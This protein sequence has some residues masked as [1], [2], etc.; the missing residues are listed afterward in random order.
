[1]LEVE[2]TSPSIVD[3]A[4]ASVHLIPPWPSIE[5]SAYPATHGHYGSSVEAQHG[6]QPR[7]DVFGPSEAGSPGQSRTEASIAT[8]A[9]EGSRRI[10]DAGGFS[11]H[12]SSSGSSSSPIGRARSRRERQSHDRPI[13]RSTSARL[14]LSN[15]EHAISSVGDPTLVFEDPR[16]QRH[17]GLAPSSTARTRRE[18]AVAVNMLRHVDATSSAPTPTLM[19][20]AL[21]DAFFVAFSPGAPAFGVAGMTDFPWMGIWKKIT[22]ER[23]RRGRRNVHLG[24]E[25]GVSPMPVAAR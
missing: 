12:S 9:F 7:L 11:I 13:G 18:P 2:A 22:A 5:P 8:Y 4:S 17:P 20:P 10:N 6:P 19:D 21:A 25:F 16:R 1:M 15:G 23:N 3:K 14:A 24:M